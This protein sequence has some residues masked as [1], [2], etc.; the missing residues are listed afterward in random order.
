MVQPSYDSWPIL[1]PDAETILQSERRPLEA[2]ANDRVAAI[3]FRQA[4]D[5]KNC[6]ALVAR[7]IDRDLLFDPQLGPSPQL[8][9]AAVPEGRYSIDAVVDGLNATPTD[10]IRID[11]GTSLGYRGHD[12]EAFFEHSLATHKLFASLFHNE[13][14]PMSIIYDSLQELTEQHV[15]TA[16]ESDG[17]RYGP[18]I[19]R[20]H[21]G[22]Y[23]YPP[24]F[25]SVRLREKRSDF[26]VYRFDNQFAGVLVLQNTSIADRT[27]H[28]VL[29]RV[30]WN[31]ELDPYLRDNTFHRYARDHAIPHRELVLQP[32]DLYFFN[33]RLIHEVPGVAGEVPRVVMATFIGYRADDPEL[34]VWS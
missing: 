18:A 29:H 24:H 19:I 4:F 22:G 6:Q 21:Y 30:L 28:C 13:P 23:T 33:T 3:V 20:A 5:R 1:E 2:L 27:A 31:P 16:Y 12:R 10:H 32:G 11:I 9:Q 8:A 25:D 14:N 34:F 7:L 17:R 15:V 26:A